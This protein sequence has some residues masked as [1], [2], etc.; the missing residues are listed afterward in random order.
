MDEF[1]IKAVQLARVVVNEFA[2]VNVHAV[3]PI[4]NEAGVARAAERPHGVAAGRVDVAVVAAVGDAGAPGRARA[5]A[6]Q[7]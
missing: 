2:L 4:P 3:R 5:A 1:D 7:C 6:A